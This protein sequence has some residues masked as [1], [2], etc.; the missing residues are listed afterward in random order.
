MLT[1]ASRKSRLNV[2]AGFGLRLPVV[3]RLSLAEH[4]V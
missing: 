3:L 1:R 2:R 4:I